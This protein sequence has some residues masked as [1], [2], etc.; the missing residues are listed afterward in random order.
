MTASTSNQVVVELLLANNQYLAKLTESQNKTKE[1]AN[2]ASQSM[3]ASFSAI[4]GSIVAMVGSQAVQYIREFY[5]EAAKYD[6]IRRGYEN[7]T[8]SYGVNSKKLVESMQEASQG[9]LSQT[10]AMRASS[11]AIQLMGEDVIKMLPRM[12]Q[13]AKAAARSNGVEVSQMMDDL[14]TAAGRRSTMILDNLGISSVT[15][16]QKQEEY[17]RKLGKTRDTL[18]EAEKSAAFFYAITEAGGEIVDR[19]GD[20]TLTLGEQTQALTARYSDFK[21]AIFDQLIPALMQSTGGMNESTASFEAAGAAIG[22]T[23]AIIINMVRTFANSLKMVWGAMTFDLDTISNGWEGLKQSIEDTGKSVLNFGKTTTN[24]FD[25]VNKSMTGALT[26]I[27]AAQKAQEKLNNQMAAGTGEDKFFDEFWKSAMKHMKQ[28]ED[29]AKALKDGVKSVFGEV[30]GS[31]SSMMDNVNNIF[32]NMADQ[33]IAHLDSMKNRMGMLIDYAKTAA[34]ESA[35]VQEETTMQANER[36]ITTLQKQIAKTYSLKK[37]QDL[38]EQLAAKQDYQKR[39]Q[40]EDDYNK[41][42]LIMEAY[43][44]YMSIT[45]QRREFERNKAF[46]ISMVWVNAAAAIVAAWLAAWQMQSSGGAWAAAIALGA[47]STGL[48]LAMAGVQT[49]LISSQTGPGFARGAWDIPYTMPA[50]VHQGETIIPRPFAEDFREA[51]AG[52]GAEEINVN[53]HLD[54]DLIHK[55]VVKRDKKQARLAGAV[56]R[57]SY[58][59]AY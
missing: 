32:S 5:N 24:V 34:L 31:V 7:L 22:S 52:G 8:A 13:I 37:K 15:A 36:E 58:A 1:F 4:K 21:N 45:R 28:I 11:N 42:K 47:I 50:V 10:D 26:A 23:L 44:E 6:T 40:I 20:S 55:A 3:T 49:A 30:S 29:E 53:L 38:R 18:T 25:N 48:M 2:K 56:S 39:L 17:A 16:G 9:T 19:A 51:M 59:G 27:Y 43:M 54:G 46:Q 33:A 14:V 35:G 41:R 57:M 12:T